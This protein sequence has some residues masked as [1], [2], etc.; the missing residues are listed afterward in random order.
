M[1]DV[2]RVESLHTF[3]E[4]SQRRSESGHVERLKWLWRRRRGGLGTAVFLWRAGTHC[5]QRR[6]KIEAVD[7]LHG[8]KPG[9]ALGNEFVERYEVGVRQAGEG[10][11]FVLE[12]V[13]RDRLHLLQG[14]QSDGRAAVPVDRFVDDPHSSFADLP[15]DFKAVGNARD[16]DPTRVVHGFTVSPG[17]SASIQRPGGISTYYG[18]WV[19]GV[20]RF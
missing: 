6:D 5:A 3:R 11:E 20:F 8:E 19:L 9:T 13:K 7:E 1:D 18:D 16:D 2:R 10:T 17:S 15:Q 14:L 12:S 4:L